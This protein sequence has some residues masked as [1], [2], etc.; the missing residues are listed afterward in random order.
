MLCPKCGNRAIMTHWL[1]QKG[2]DA[3]LRQYKCLTFGHIF[4]TPTGR[5]GRVKKGG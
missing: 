2:M 3:F 4:Y 1:P 5:R